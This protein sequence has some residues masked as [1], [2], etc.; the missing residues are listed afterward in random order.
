MQEDRPSRDAPLVVLGYATPSGRVALEQHTDGVVARLPVQALGSVLAV[1]LTALFVSLGLLGGLAWVVFESGVIQT[2]AALIALIFIAAPIVGS[3]V[4]AMVSLAH[5]VTSCV[6][7]GEIRV[8][9]RSLSIRL[10]G[11]CRALE[12]DWERG[13]VDD[14]RLSRYK[15]SWARVEMELWVLSDDGHQVVLKLVW[16]GE[17]GMDAMEKSLRA[18]LGLG[19]DFDWGPPGTGLAG[20][21]V[22]S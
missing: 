9:D 14:L 20:V 5:D 7:A 11:F 13:Q 6:V 2:P 12:Y 4:V 22:G 21:G 1:W 18:A 10:P 15:R 8:I 3:A 19:R 16:P 17:D